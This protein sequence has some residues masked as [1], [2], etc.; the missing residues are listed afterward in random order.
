M[1]KNEND[2]TT[3]AER[4]AARI[5]ISLDATQRNV[6]ALRT[7]ITNAIQAIVQDADALRTA[8]REGGAERVYT[9]RLETH[10]RQLLEARAEFERARDV[11]TTLSRLVE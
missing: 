3:N 10:V 9:S 8:N 4:T 6:A 7:T 11:E 5:A 1:T 2:A